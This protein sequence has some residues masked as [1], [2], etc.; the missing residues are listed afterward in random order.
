MRNIDVFEATEG[1]VEKVSDI[2]EEKDKAKQDP[3]MLLSELLAS[4]P[5]KLK[6][7]LRPDNKF[8]SDLMKRL[9]EKREQSI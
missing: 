3:E 8:A 2:V 5:R 9:Q 4:A 6:R 7:Q 1:L